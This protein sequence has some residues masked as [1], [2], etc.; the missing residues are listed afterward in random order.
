MADLSSIVLPADF[1]P[2]GVS[3]CDARQ[4]K[5]YLYQLTEQLRYVLSNLD[6]DNMTASYN[7]G[8]A[9]AGVQ[10]AAL[11]EQQ[12]QD[13]SRLK[14]NLVETATK[15]AHD[16]QSALTQADDRLKAEVT[17][18]YAA[19]NESTQAELEALVDSRVTQT[20]RALCVE[21]SS[22]STLSQKTAEALEMLESRQ[23]TWFRFTADGLELGKNENGTASPYMLRIDNEKL[24]FL[25]YGTPVAYLQY[26][27]L[28]VTAA[29]VSD[30]LSIGG[31]AGE[32]F[33]D[34]ITTAT[35]L[36]VKWR[37]N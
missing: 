19:Q 1:S 12:K 28:Y 15:I 16:Y 10:V 7:A 36:G 27:R 32:G 21:L 26:N 6:S 37:A 30:R 22:L 11:S 24:A 14:Q 34:F 33:Y 4:L 31:S 20:S 2:Q 23:D 18:Q 3:A 5:S 25:R 17:E 35:G 13:F 8:V 29:E 9:A